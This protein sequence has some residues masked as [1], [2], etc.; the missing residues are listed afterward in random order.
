[1]HRANK[2][3]RSPLPQI[4]VRDNQVV[5]HVKDNGRGIAARDRVRIFELFRRA[6]AQDQPGDGIGL[7]H[8]QAL[9]RRLGGRIEVESIMGEGSC[10]TVTLPLS[11]AD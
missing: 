2:K 8:V 4:R 5:I 1:M 9:L 7:P 3:H 6:G 11:P 10:F